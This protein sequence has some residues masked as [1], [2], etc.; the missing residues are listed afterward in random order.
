MSSTKS[1]DYWQK[2]SDS[3]QNAGETTNKR[4]KEY[5]QVDIDF[6]RRHL[7]KSDDILDV[8]SGSGLVVNEIVN[9]VNSII[10]V[11]TFEGLT[12]FIH[13]DVL[14]INTPLTDFNIRKQFDKVVCTGVTHFFNKEDVT[15]IYK[16]MV[17]MLKPGGLLIMRSHCGLEETV[18]IDG[19]SE[20]LNSEYFAEYRQ[21]EIEKDLLKEVGF[22]SVE[23][24]DE[25]SDS[26]NV[27]D[28]TRHYYFV[29]KK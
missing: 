20:E 29:C 9:D 5:L 3:I 18:V 13:E 26:L 14:V 15:K 6:V 12:K 4:N 27:W 21:L 17:K 23:V 28:N 24:F 25:V 19:K 2:M 16:A 1:K 11:E 7:D 10:A 22:S 8:G